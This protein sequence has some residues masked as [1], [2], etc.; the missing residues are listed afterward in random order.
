M[1][2]RQWKEKDGRAW[3]ELPGSG[4]INI[5]PKESEFEWRVDYWN[6]EKWIFKKGMENSM[7]RA[8]HTATEFAR[9]IEPKG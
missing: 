2:K 9:N 7:D 1:K 5:Q 6:G 8:K 3:T 4:S